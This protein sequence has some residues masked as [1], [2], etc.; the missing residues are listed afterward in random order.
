MEL[1]SRQQRT[2]TANGGCEGDDTNRFHLVYW[3]FV[4]AVSLR[5]VVREWLVGAS[6]GEGA[7]GYSW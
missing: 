7:R 6:N 2:D 4:V 5:L 3:T 1:R